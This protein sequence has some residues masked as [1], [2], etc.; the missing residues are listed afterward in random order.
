MRSPVPNPLPTPP[1][2]PGARSLSDSCPASLTEPVLG[3]PPLTRGGP[4]PDPEY[5]VP[6]PRAPPVPALYEVLCELGR[7]GMGASTRN[8][9]RPNRLVAL[10]MILTGRTP[11]TGPARSAPR[12]M[13]WP[14]AAPQH[15]PNPRCRGAQR[16]APSFSLEYC[17]ASALPAAGRGAPPPGYAARLVETLANAV[18]HAH[19]HCVSTATF[20]PAHVLLAR[21]N[22]AR[23][24]RPPWAK[25]PGR[26]CG[27]QPKLTGLGLAKQLDEARAAAAARTG[28][29]VVHVP[30]GN[31]PPASRT[32]SFPP[33]TRIRAGRHPLRAATGRPPFRAATALT[34]WCR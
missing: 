17:G 22:P 34:R 33:P 14:A 31:M 6:T 12:R 30:G 7:G 9:A 19:S 29:A 27:L 4:P 10:K 21:A 2:R 11:T 1:L 23:K 3:T 16:P 18:H 20:K 24:T 26:R 13:R 25:G 8:T 5:R 32:M 28:R 15:R